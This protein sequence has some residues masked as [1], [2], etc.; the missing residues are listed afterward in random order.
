[1]TH[2]DILQAER[3]GCPFP[4]DEPLLYCADCGEGIYENETY[5]DI[6][7]CEDCAD[8]HTW[9]R[10]PDEGDGP[11]ICGDCG[12]MVEPWALYASLPN[13]EGDFCAGCFEK[14][15]VTAYAPCH[16]LLEGVP[17]HAV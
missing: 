16:V 10:Y 15:K 3:T 4:P 7:I 8:L 6:G 9:T 5:H 13:G 11:V 2:P 17:T 14:T 12:D 1:M